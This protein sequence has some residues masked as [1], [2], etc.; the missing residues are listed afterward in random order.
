MTLIEI[1]TEIQKALDNMPEEALSE[2]LDIV[3]KFQHQ[4]SDDLK[5]S[6]NFKKILEKHKGLL[7][8]LA[9]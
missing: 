4:S 1:K 3:K 8:R 5:T 7:S 9:Q 6:E 2:I